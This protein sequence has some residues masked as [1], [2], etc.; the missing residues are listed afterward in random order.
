MVMR[1]SVMFF[2][3]IGALVGSL[4]GAAWMIGARLWPGQ[5]LVAAAA[6]M[7]MELLLTGAR[8]TGGLARAADGF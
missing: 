7:L 5:L 8:G 2:P 4:C 6:S 1:R 3:L